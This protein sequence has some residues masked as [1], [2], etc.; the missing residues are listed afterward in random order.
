MWTKNAVLFSM[1]Q[2]KVGIYLDFSIPELLGHLGL[3]VK[4]T[5]IEGTL[6]KHLKCP[7]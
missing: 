2:V 4:Y 5:T 3:T 7:S 6:S 1:S